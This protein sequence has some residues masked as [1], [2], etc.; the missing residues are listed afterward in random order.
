M[1]RPPAARES[2]RFDDTA[3]LLHCITRP[4]ELNGVFRRHA[5]FRLR[6]W[7]KR[8]CCRDSFDARRTR[9]FVEFFNGNRS[10]FYRFNLWYCSF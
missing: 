9:S 3:G 10:N 8:T 5:T 7:P 6:V 1:D 4:P 2:T